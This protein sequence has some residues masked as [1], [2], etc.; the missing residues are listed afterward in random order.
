MGVHLCIE[1]ATVFLVAEALRLAFNEQHLSA[2]LL[3]V[4]PCMVCKECLNYWTENR[5]KKIAVKM[6]E[7]AEQ[8]DKE[9]GGSRTK[10]EAPEA[11]RTGKQ[12][13]KRT[14]VLTE[15]EKRELHFAEILGITEP[16]DLEEAEANYR[17][18]IQLTHPDTHGNSPENNRRSADLNEAIEF[19]QKKLA[20]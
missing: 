18:R 2:W 1:P 11:T 7:K 15:E 13:M 19:F 4:A 5:L 12:T 6:R 14:V 9:L 20:G 17:E 16:H 10:T 3:I 8:L